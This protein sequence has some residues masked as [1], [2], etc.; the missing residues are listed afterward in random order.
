MEKQ[1]LKPEKYARTEIQKK[2]KIVKARRKS[3]GKNII[4]FMRDFGLTKHVKQLETKQ[5]RCGGGIY[6]PIW[7]HNFGIIIPGWV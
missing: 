3:R 1:K 4:K 7:E 6:I 5:L 2:K